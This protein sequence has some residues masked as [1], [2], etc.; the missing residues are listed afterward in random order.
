[1]D[2][3]ILGALNVT[4]MAVAF[5]GRIRQAAWLYIALQVPWSLW[6]VETRNYGFLLIGFGSLA[7]SIITLARLRETRKTISEERSPEC[8]T[9]T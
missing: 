9:R 7:V 1:M 2:S 4:A 5:S 8:R 6:D 3:F